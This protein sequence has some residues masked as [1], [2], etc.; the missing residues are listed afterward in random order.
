MSKV[1][2]TPNVMGAMA[3]EFRKIAMAAE[4]Q[5]GHSQRRVASRLSWEPGS[6]FITSGGSMVHGSPGCCGDAEAAEFTQSRLVPDLIRHAESALRQGRKVVCLSEGGVNGE[7][8]S[9]QRALS[10]AIDQLHRKPHH[11]GKIIHDSWDDEDVRA[12]GETRDG[13]LH[14]DRDSPIFKRLVQ[15]F[16]DPDLVDAALQAGLSGKG[17]K[18][19]GQILASAQAQSKLMSM[20]APPTNVAKLQALVNPEE[21]GGPRT[22]LS[23]VMEHYHHERRKNLV[24]KVKDHEGQG[25]VVVMAP[26]HRHVPHVQAALRS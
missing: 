1:R 20:G 3:D 24:K 16:R 18:Q 4:Q 8:G 23:A 12:I 26:H 21:S 15:V 14:I 22:Q 11:A 19:T 25:H 9:E 10:D 7:E 6:V 13:H 5:P 17:K 2:V